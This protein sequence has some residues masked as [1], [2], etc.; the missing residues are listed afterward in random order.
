M[1]PQMTEVRPPVQLRIADDIR[2]QIEKGVLQP[3]DSLPPLHE[4]AE[5]WSC[6]ITSARNAITLLKTQ[7]LITGGRGKAPVVRVPSR[8][9]VRTSARHQAEKDRAIAPAGERV[10]HGEAED[11]LGLPLDDVDFRADYL[12][13]PA[14][15]ELA[16]V[17]GCQPGENLLRKQYEARDR[18][19]WTRYSFSVSYVPARLLES[20][21]E[22]LSSEC[23][24]WPGGHQ[25]QF[26]MVGIEIA[27]IVDEVNARMPTTVEA[28][29]WGLEDGVPLLVV[30]RISIDTDGRVVEVS[31]AQ[32]PAD[33]T[34]LRFPTPLKPWSE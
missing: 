1:D 11:D 19:G 13:M 23:E 28:Q 2:V 3:G 17:F 20:R 27:E 34:L 5:R 18:S 16:A 32:Y 14:T 9:V 30:R 7:G 10:V 12:L 22:L 21:P 31:D 26:R 25:H 15:E 29:R 8:R 24:P 6:S 4:L 33:R